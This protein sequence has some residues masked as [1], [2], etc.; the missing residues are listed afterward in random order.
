MIHLGPRDKTVFTARLEK[1]RR[2]RG[3]ARLGSIESRRRSTKACT[4]SDRPNLALGSRRSD[5]WP[6][7]APELHPKA[8]RLRRAALPANRAHTADF[9]R[10][11]E[12]LGPTFMSPGNQVVRQ[13]GM[14]YSLSIYFMLALL[15][16]SIPSAKAQK[17]VPEIRF[18]EENHVQVNPEVNGPPREALVRPTSA[19]SGVAWSRRGRT[20]WG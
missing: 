5:Q 9:A 11:A 12:R 3:R 7:G 4:T 15:A 6:C 13:H 17:A 2:E 16:V 19:S 20:Q 14:E 10:E 1:F 8:G 18:P